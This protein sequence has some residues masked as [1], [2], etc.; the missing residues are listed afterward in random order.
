MKNLKKKN[1]ILKFMVLSIIFS[2]FIL[3]GFKAYKPV[4]IYVNDELIKSDQEPFI[5]DSRVFLPLRA[6]AE[7]LGA[8]VTYK[9]ENKSINIERDDSNIYLAIGD[10]MA[11]I[12]NKKMA[13]LALLDCPPIIKNNRTFLPLRSVAELL[14][15]IVEWDGNIRAVYIN[16]E[17]NLPKYINE[18]NAASEVLLRLKELQII[19]DK[20]YVTD[21]KK[22]SVKFLDES[23]QGYFVSVRK[24][25]PIDKDLSELVG[26]YFINDVGTLLLE[27]DPL[28]DDFKLLI[29][30]N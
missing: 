4:K 23:D 5:L 10:D 16:E 11:W 2:A 3:S 24:D 22:Y 20:A 25:N 30:V 26:Q 21:V 17:S 12:S 18:N 13:G 6:V 28:K 15:M 29:G 8:K 1:M 9:K 19:D 7:N 27:Y 14:G